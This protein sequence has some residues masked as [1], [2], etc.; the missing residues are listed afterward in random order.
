MYNSSTPEIFDLILADVLQTPLTA[1]IISPAADDSPRSETGSLDGAAYEHLEE[2]AI[3]TETQ[4]ARA[5]SADR[6]RRHLDHP[7]PG[8]VHAE[9]SVERSS[10]AEGVNCIERTE[11]SGLHPG[12]RRK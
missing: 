8:I 5:E 12:W 2:H 10:Q 9:F 11:N 7:W 3:L 1:R 4:G 6:P